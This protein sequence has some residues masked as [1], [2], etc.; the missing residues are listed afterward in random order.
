VSAPERRE[1]DVVEVIA[2]RGREAEVARALAGE[3]A[4][5]VALG[6]WLALGPRGER[7]SAARRLEASL[8]GLAHVID[9]SAGYAA[10]RLS[11]PAARDILA[12]GCR[13]DLHPAV[14]PVG[15]TARTLI[16]Q[17]T[18]VIHLADAQPSFDIL[19]PAPLARSFLHH[20]GTVAAQ[21][22]AAAKG[23]S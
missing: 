9:Q 20:L 22:A 1:V 13:I 12:R 15:R 5:A 16:A 7:G 11:G 6:T 23:S 19:V 18:V 3:T 21:L 10:M 2:R 14:F 4:L 8:A 17:T